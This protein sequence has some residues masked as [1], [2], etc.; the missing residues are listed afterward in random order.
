MS[1]ILYFLSIPVAFTG[2]VLGFATTTVQEILSYV[3]SRSRRSSVLLPGVDPV[4]T[5]NYKTKAFGNPQRPIGSRD[6]TCRP[7]NAC[8]SCHSQ[9]SLRRDLREETSRHCTCELEIPALGKKNW[10]NHEFESS[11]GYILTAF[12][13]LQS[14]KQTKPPKN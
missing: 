1:L 9:S 13:C 8:L 2:S 12:N 14:D 10:E 6:G 11:L 7:H 3:N 5:T 4:E